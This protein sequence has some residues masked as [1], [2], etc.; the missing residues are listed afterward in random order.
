VICA[1]H[2]ERNQQLPADRIELYDACC[3]MLLV[4]RGAEQRL[5]VEARDYPQLSYRFMRALLDDLAYWMLQNNWASVP[6]QRV[7]ERFTRKLRDMEGGAR[8]I[9]G[10]HVTR[11]FVERS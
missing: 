11:L 8:G 3:Q 7:H 9:P 6:E 1:L 4:R 5:L 2:R 10:A